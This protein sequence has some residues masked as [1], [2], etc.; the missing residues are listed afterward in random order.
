MESS[1]ANC[2]PQNRTGVSIYEAG[3]G[4]AIKISKSWMRNTKNTLINFIFS[5][6][7]KI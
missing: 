2:C 6:T 7:Y 3:T 5:V 4:D 1:A